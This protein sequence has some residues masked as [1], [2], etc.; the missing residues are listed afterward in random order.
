MSWITW[1][2]T[3]LT[4]L[5]GSPEGMAVVMAVVSALV[6]AVGGQ[7][8]LLSRLLTMLMD[9]LRGTTTT[10]TVSRVPKN[11]GAALLAVLL[12][13]ALAHAGDPRDSTVYVRRE[14]G[15]GVAECGTGTV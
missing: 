3:F 12:L 11:L 15:G 2:V 8:P 6:G 13:P 7:H 4:Q 1:V 10:V 5:T 9:L 14:V